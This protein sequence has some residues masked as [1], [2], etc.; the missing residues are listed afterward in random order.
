MMLVNAV[1]DNMTKYS[2]AD[3]SHD[4]LA[5]TLATTQSPK[6][7]YTSNRELHSYPMKHMIWT[8]KAQDTMQDNRP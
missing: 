4:S 1:A 6:A 7:K 8:G 2:N 3:Y 5:H